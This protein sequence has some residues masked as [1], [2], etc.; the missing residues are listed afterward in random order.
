MLT[1]RGEAADNPELV[2]G[3]WVMRCEARSLDDIRTTGDLPGGVEDAVKA[4]SQEFTPSGAATA[5]TATD[6][7]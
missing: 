3:E 4:F 6:E 1:S 2:T 5:T 7:A